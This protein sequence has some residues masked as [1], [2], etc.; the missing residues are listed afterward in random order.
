MGLAVV[1][2]GV[3]VVLEA[4]DVSV[5]TEYDEVD[6][7]CGTVMTVIVVRLLLN[8]RAF[9]PVLQL[10]AGAGSL[11]WQQKEGSPSVL[12]EHGYSAQGPLVFLS[13]WSYS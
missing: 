4:I 13:S 11:R 6:G 8:M 2:A 9:S 10:Q 7:A 3:A 1:V 12:T 5:D